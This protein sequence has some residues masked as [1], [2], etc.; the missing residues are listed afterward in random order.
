MSEASHRLVDEDDGNLTLPETKPLGSLPMVR[1]RS[2]ASIF[3]GLLL[4]AVPA[5]AQLQPEDADLDGHQDEIDNCPLV[6]NPD[7]NELCVHSGLLQS[8]TATASPFA[9]PSL[10]YD[11][12]FGTPPHTVGQPPVAG[13]G[14]A[15]RN[16]PTAIRVGSPTVVAAEGVMDQQPL[17]L[18][19]GTATFDQLAFATSQFDGGFS[20][21]FPTYHFELTV[22]VVQNAGELAIF[23]DGPSA[24]AVRF[25]PDGRI[26]A[27][28]LGAGGYIETIGQWEAGV[29]MRLVVD[30]DR[31]GEQWTIA[32]D[33][34]DVFSGHY[35]I[36]CCHGMRMLRPSATRGT[37]AAIDDVL[38]A[39]RPLRLVDVDIKPGSD[40][41]FINPF[42]PALIPV[43][44]LGSGTVD[45]T[46][47]DLAT[48]KFGPGGAARVDDVNEDGEFVDDDDFLD[49]VV[50]FRPAETGIAIGDTEACL[51]GKTL[52][53]VPILGCDDVRTAVGAC[54]FGFE[55]AFVV[56]LLAWGY[57][58]RRRQAA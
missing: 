53:G 30:I 49:L 23:F 50:H 3:A 15:P 14:P 57:R 9:P 37:I 46:G 6:Y 47:V 4:V 20:F 31:P 19:S 17:R 43:A 7:Q 1:L 18:G 40:P 35:R 12:D 58:R 21:Q 26:N 27:R 13:G 11:V 55:L 5:S 56:P 24:H 34:E 36:S 41:N 42:A 54:G 28:T 38:V 52:G 10:L 51:T 29:P 22:M 32:L 8:S 33:G 25:K 48:L 39:D 2:L 45:V 16:V 44:I